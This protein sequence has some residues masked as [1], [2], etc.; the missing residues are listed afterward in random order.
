MIA[1]PS[2]LTVLA[3]SLLITRIGAMALMLTGLPAESARFQARSAFTGV[4]YPAKECEDVVAHPVRRRIVMLLMLLGNLGVGAVVA[5]VMLSFMQTA[6]ADRWWVPMS[7]LIA[8]LLVLWLAARSRYLE[9]HLNRAISWVL[10]RWGHLEER[11][12]AAILHLREGYAVSEMVVQGNGWLANKTLIELKLPNE[13]VL[14]LG[15]QRK[16][17]TFLG[18]PRSDTTI[19]AEDTLIVYGSEK[20]VKELDLRRRGKQGDAAHIEAVEKHQDKMQSASSVVD[21]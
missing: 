15:I 7:T 10:R 21:E 13:G 19:L 14:V 12:F 9:R 2:L 11:D 6:R 3:I 4:G 17:G 20:R 8:G 5:T 16:D 1:I 18:S